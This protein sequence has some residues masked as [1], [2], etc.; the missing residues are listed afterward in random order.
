LNDINGVI[1]P[2]VNNRRAVVVD[3]L[4]LWC[5]DPCAKTEIGGNY[6]PD[7]KG[8]TT[9]SLIRKVL[10]KGREGKVSTGLD[11]YSVLGPGAA[12]AILSYAGYS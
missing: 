6:R 12:G 7:R 9:L 3:F 4:T 1:P 11:V 2:S 5:M 10:G 8:V